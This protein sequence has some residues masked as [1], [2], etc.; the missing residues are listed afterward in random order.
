M[1]EDIAQKIEKALGLFLRLDNFG[2]ALTARQIGLTPPA[3]EAGIRGAFLSFT[4][5]NGE[6]ALDIVIDDMEFELSPSDMEASAS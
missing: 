5:N 3:D 1:E 6:G 4:V 2:K